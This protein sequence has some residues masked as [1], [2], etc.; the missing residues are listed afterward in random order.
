[1][2]HFVLEEECQGDAEAYKGK[3]AKPKKNQNAC[4]KANHTQK[5]LEAIPYSYS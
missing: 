1:M 4:L 2:W 5:K 3:P